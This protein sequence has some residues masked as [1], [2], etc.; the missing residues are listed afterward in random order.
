LQ[1]SAEA[2][3]A[4]VRTATAYRVTLPKLAETGHNDFLKGIRF[5]PRAILELR[6]GPKEKD[7]QVSD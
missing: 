6:F 4:V 7:G 1:F 5:A 3:R 2:P